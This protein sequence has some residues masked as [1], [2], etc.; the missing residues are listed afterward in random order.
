MKKVL[1][2]FK[3]LSLRWKLTILFFEISWMIFSISHFF[4]KEPLLFSLMLALSDIQ[5]F[6]IFFLILITA[7]FIF[8][9]LLAFVFDFIMNKFNLNL[10]LNLNNFALVVGI[11]LLI[12]LFSVG[13][14][15]Y[16]LFS[17]LLLNLKK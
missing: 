12:N 6:L 4:L 1:D 15:I 7:L 9:Y 17:I 3:N 14:W 11:F 16:F 10:N 2:W 8:C 13:Y 5:F